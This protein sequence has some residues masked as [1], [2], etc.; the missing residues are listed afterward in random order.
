LVMPSFTK[1]VDPRRESLANAFKLNASEDELDYFSLLSLMFGM[2]GLFLRYRI[3][4]WQALVCC[5]ISFANAKTSDVDLKHILSSFS[6]AI[7]GLGMAYFGP[8]SRFFQ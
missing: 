2:M 7:M 4:V 8:Q 6:I 5:I 3:F 1:T